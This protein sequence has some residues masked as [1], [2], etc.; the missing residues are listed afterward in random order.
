VSEGQKADAVAPLYGKEES[1]FVEPR[2]D[3][4]RSEAN[5]RCIQVESQGL[6]N[7]EN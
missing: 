4:L 1:F 3:Q 7:G 2:R 6:C 5:R